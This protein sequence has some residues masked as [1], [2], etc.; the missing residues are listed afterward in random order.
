M[1]P[2]IW[3]AHNFSSKTVLQQSAS[4]GLS[5]LMKTIGNTLNI[6]LHDLNQSVTVLEMQASAQDTLSACKS[7]MDFQCLYAA[8]THCCQVR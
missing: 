5:L 8:G 1:S 4:I 3:K 7:L 2:S 6:L